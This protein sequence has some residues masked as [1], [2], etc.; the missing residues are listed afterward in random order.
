MNSLPRFLYWGDIQDSNINVIVPRNPA[1]LLA[2]A[3]FV[4]SDEF[5]AAIRAIDQKVAVT[6]ATMV[7]VPFD[8]LHW[9]RIAEK[10]YPNGLP[11]PDT[12]DPSQW[13]FAGWPAESAAPL[14]TASARLLGYRW[15][16]ELDEK[17]RLSKRARALA[18]RCEDLTKFA[19][20]D[21]IVC[22]P[23]VRGVEPA[24]ARLE[25]LL[26]AAGMS[27]AKVRE[28]AGGSDL[29]DWL[30]DSFFEEHCKL[31]HNR[32][33]VWHI[34]DGRKRDG[35]H[36]LVN[37]HKLSEEKGGGRK[38]LESLTYS[39]LGEWIT[40]Q[41]DGVKRGEGGAEDRLAAA[42]E[43]QNRLRLIL[44]GE[45]PFDLFVRWKPLAEQPVG[46]EPDINDGV[47]MNI[48]PFMASDLPGG[49]AGAGVLRW[50][51]NIKWDKDR[52]KELKRSKEEYPWFWNW[53]GKV[54]D[55][56]GT[57]KTPDGN[58]WND[59][60]YTNKAKQAARAAVKKEGK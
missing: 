11:E 59:C 36:A 23:A 20:D 5:P 50:K 15:P 58:R 40:R 51:P 33:F 7:K 55:F 60:H 10:E 25:G 52:G 47:R 43:L 27:P 46:W 22:I 30:R 12:T 16:A 57:G 29:D 6:N 41:K 35:F 17:L 34:W 24:A 38:L 42:I 8:V 39:Y 13:P 3:A 19:A 2:L 54:V 28:L 49:R 9:R 26:A 21:G 53:N 18:E 45:P 31:F 37:Y 56:M 48:R 14:H 4:L 1:D 32:P 44:E